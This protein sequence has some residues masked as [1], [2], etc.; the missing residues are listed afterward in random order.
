M[1]S[2][3]TKKF[4]FYIKKINIGT[5]K[6]DHYWLTIFSIVVAYFLIDN[7]DKKSWFFEEIFLL[8]DICMNITF[9]MPFL[10]LSDIKI[11][12]NNRELKSMSYIIMVPL[13]ITK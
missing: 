1:Q 7:K 3:F 2:S 10:T 9:G 8:A 5:K 12:F 4:G 13:S 6:I 11:D